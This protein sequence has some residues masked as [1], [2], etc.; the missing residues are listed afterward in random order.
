MSAEIVVREWFAFRVRPRHEKSVALH[1]REKSEECFVPL[2]KKSR[3]WAKRVVHIELPLISGYV[4]CRSHRYGMLPIL[5]TPGIVDVIRAGNAPLPIPDSEIASL[6]RAISAELPIEPCP[7]VEVG[8]RVQIRSGPLAGV[9]GI[10]NDRRKSDQ[11]I[12]SVALLRRS[13]LVQIEENQLYD[14]DPLALPPERAIA[15]AYSA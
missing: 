9:V 2:I 1:L 15:T 3:L 8:Q 6:E 12:L 4:F 7:Y 14:A 10:V 11:L 5:K 13:V